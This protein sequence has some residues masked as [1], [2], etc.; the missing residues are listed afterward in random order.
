MQAQTYT[1]A[2]YAAGTVQPVM[3]TAP[4]TTPVPQPLPTSQNYARPPKQKKGFMASI[5]GT[6]EK[7]TDKAQ[8]NWNESTDERFRRY[9]GFPFSELLFGE[10]WGEVWTGNQLVSCSVYLSTNWLCVLAKVKDPITHN[11][12]PLRA[13][14]ALRDIIRIQRAITLPS[15]R[16]GPPIIQAITDPSVRA[17]SLQVFTRDGLLHQF[18][19]FYNY[20]K[21][22]AT[23]EHLWHQATIAQQPAAQPSIS[24]AAPNTVPL[25]QYPQPPVLQKQF[26]PA[27]EAHLQQP[28]TQAGGMPYQQPMTQAGG[29]PYQQTHSYT[30]QTQ[31]YVQQPP[32][33]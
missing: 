32:A 17:D 24:T 16:G 9:F 30:Q 2:T 8:R 1:P 3:L 6:W 5:K 23:L 27:T 29:M 13:Q 28:M 33:Q 26:V 12:V 10:F 22:L 14:I 7:F 19:R 25:A 21:L 15:M 11:K 31:T 20:E 18:T 4:P